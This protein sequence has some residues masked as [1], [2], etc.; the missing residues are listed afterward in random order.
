MVIHLRA[1]NGWNGILEDASLFDVIHDG[2]AA[3]AAFPR[4]GAALYA[5]MLAIMPDCSWTSQNLA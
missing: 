1:A 4:C 2:A 5:A 3:A